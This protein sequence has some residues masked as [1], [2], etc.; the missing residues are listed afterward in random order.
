MTNETLDVRGFNCPLPVLKAKK[1]LSDLAAGA[2]LEILSTDA[3][4]R[5]DFAAFCKAAGHTL[6]SEDEKD[7]VFHVVIQKAV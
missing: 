5:D 4:S 1:A 2:T 3:S 6:V 7:G